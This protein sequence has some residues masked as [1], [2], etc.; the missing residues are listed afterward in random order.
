MPR[1]YRMDTLAFEKGSLSITVYSIV[2]GKKAIG[3]WLVS[4]RLKSR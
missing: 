2:N 3:H 1:L 4:Y